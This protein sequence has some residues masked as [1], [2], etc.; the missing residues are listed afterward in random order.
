MHTEKK[1]RYYGTIKISLCILWKKTEP[2]G[3]GG[4]EGGQAEPPGSKAD[5]EETWL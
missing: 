2:E 4:V 5:V 1:I 3:S